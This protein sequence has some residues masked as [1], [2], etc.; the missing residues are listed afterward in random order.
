[1]TKRYPPRELGQTKMKPVVDWWNILRP[2]VY[3]GL[4]IRK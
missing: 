1:M 4:G 2:L 3:V